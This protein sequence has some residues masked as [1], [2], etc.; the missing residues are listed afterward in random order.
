VLGTLLLENCLQHT[1]QLCPIRHALR[2]GVET[3]VAGE[4]WKAE[5]AA[6]GQ[7]LKGISAQSMIK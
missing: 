7:K 5:G 4:V 3:G 2:I 1:L 6:Q